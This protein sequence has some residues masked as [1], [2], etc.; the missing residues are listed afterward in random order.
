MVQFIMILVQALPMNA[1]AK[2]ILC[3]ILVVVGRIAFG[4]G[5]VGG[6]VAPALVVH[7][8]METVVLALVAV[9]VLLEKRR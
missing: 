3:A 6:I 8:N 1:I 7:M 2:T 4:A 5:R 9:D